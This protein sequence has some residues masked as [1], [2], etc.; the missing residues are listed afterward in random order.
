MTQLH[1]GFLHGGPLVG[2]ADGHLGYGAET[3]RTILSISNR[4]TTRRQGEGILV[5]AS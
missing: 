4:Q 1:D 3:T 2:M 5:D